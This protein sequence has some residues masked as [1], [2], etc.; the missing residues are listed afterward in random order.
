MIE[1]AILR[2]PDYERPVEV[3]P[4]LHGFA[5]PTS[6]QCYVVSS[7]IHAEWN[8][9]EHERRNIPVV[10]DQPTPDG[11]EEVAGV[12][13]GVGRHARLRL[14]DGVLTARYPDR[15]RMLGPLAV[16]RW[17]ARGSARTSSS[18]LRLNRGALP[19]T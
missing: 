10:A 15:H 5:N 19:T 14:P 17:A 6:T 13:C 3:G 16:H 1:P 2:I 12:R 7:W 8:R 4:P 11:P 9:I 18:R